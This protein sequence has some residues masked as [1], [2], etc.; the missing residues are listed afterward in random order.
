MI[1][2]LNQGGNLLIRAPTPQGSW[3]INPPLKRMQFGGQRDQIILFSNVCLSTENS[4]KQL[5][6]D[7]RQSFPGQVRPPF[8]H[9]AQLCFHIPTVTPHV[10]ITYFC[11]CLGW[12]WKLLL[13][14]KLVLN[15]D[16]LWIPNSLPT[17]SDPLHLF[18]A[19]Y[20]PGLLQC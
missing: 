14:G 20:K 5:R 12:H 4:E 1:I 18:P 6:P 9:T 8:T 15:E 19:N 17:I 10:C 13:R 2:L 3:R 7:P 16:E 11:K